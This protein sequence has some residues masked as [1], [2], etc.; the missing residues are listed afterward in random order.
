MVKP[1]E[2]GTID[3]LKDAG[4]DEKTIHDFMF[5]FRQ[6]DKEREQRILEKHRK[7]LVSTL[8]MAK[9]HI[10]CLDYFTYQMEKNKQ[11]IVKNKAV[12]NS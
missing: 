2:Q 12:K 5:A 4:C 9:K 8:N 6:G 1:T 10:D 3:N 7:D 11:A